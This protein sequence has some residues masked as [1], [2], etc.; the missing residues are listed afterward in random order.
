MA[1]EEIQYKPELLNAGLRNLR[2]IRL[3]AALNG[4]GM[5]AEELAV[6]A[7]YAIST[8][9]GEGFVTIPSLVGLLGFGTQ[10]NVISGL[11]YLAGANILTKVIEKV[12]G[13]V[14]GV[15]GDAHIL[16]YKMDKFT[17]MDLRKRLDRLT[18]KTKAY[19]DTHDNAQELREHIEYAKIHNGTQTTGK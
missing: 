16:N 17:R 4:K 11:E 8:G 13:R 14:Y 10:N 1:L 6:L 19:I 15:E 5:N 18:P 7:S 2:R 3:Q 9:R 12:D